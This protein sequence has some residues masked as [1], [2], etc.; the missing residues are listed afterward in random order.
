MIAALLTCVALAP[1]ASAQVSFRWQFQVGEKFYLEEVV[2]HEQTVTVAGVPVVQKL[3]NT[4]VSEF[5]VKG[6]DGEGFI[7][8]QKIVGWRNVK[9]DGGDDGDTLE[10]VAGTGLFTYQITR[11][12]VLGRMT[13]YEEFMKRLVNEFPNEAQILRDVLTPE[14]FRS[15]LVLAFD[16]LPGVSVRPGDRWEKA[17]AVPAGPFGHYLLRNQF[18]YKARTKGVDEFTS[19]GNFSFQPPREAGSFGG[20]KVSSIDFKSAG[21]R[22][23]V[24]FDAEAGRLV[25]FEMVLPLSGSMKLEMNGNQIEV[26]LQ[27]T[28]TRTI[29]LLKTRPHIGPGGDA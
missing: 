3:L 19:E 22:G 14:A 24:R 20:V 15:S 23:T 1:P 8:E 21:S 13:G 5:V 11:K 27:G 28:E 6:T 18:T 10:R 2:Q 26:M 9:N 4:R 29:R 25:R 7:L 12:G 16:F 17:I